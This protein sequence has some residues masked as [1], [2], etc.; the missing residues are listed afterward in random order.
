[1]S[2]E[3]RTYLIKQH[4][5]LFYRI[6]ILQSSDDIGGMEE[7]AQRMGAIQNRLQ[8]SEVEIQACKV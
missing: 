1:M 6:G 2:L 3:E 8:L 4:Q 5:H 7:C